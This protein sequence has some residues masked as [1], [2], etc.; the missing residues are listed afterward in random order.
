MQIVKT[1]AFGNDFLLLD[2]AAVP[3]ATDR[4]ALARKTCNRH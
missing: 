4:A 2:E 1:H 3:A